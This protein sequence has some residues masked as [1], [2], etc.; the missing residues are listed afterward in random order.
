MEED[1]DETYSPEEEE[2]AKALANEYARQTAKNTRKEYAP[3]GGFNPRV[4][5]PVARVVE[6]LKATPENYIRAQFSLSRRPIFANTL[7]GPEA[8]KRYKDWARS[9][10]ADG[11]ETENVDRSI[12]L[13]RIKA[14]LS[15]LS[16]FCGTTP[17]S[18]PKAVEK[19]LSMPEYWDGLILMLLSPTAEFKK[20]FGKT[21]KE[22]IDAF[23]G[24]RQ[25]ISELGFDVVLNY[26]DD[27]E[28]GG[29][30]DE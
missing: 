20:A 23:P 21:A 7:H 17:L 3:K 30:R 16:Y 12:L 6:K 24:L 28:E 29:E 2:L 8:V 14:T 10:V 4:W 18:D 27:E 1:D 15:Q 13:D 9:M 19:V 11:K 5:V 26:L 25:E 22:E